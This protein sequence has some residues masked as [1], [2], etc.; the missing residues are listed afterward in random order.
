MSDTILIHN[1]RVYLPDEL[2]DPGW[3]LIAGKRITQI[4]QG[5]PPVGLQST[6]SIDAG[7]KHLLPGFIDLHIHGSAGYEVMDCDPEGILGMA[8][9]LVT[10]G[11]TGFLATTL[12]APHE[13]IMAAIQA[14]KRANEQP[15]EGWAAILGVHLEGP[16]LNPERCGAQDPGQIRRADLREF[17]ELN[18]SGQVRLVTL[19]PE[20]PENLW[21][22]AACKERGITVSA[23]HTSANQE[24]MKV[25][26]ELGLNHVT[27]IYNAM[28]PLNH[29]EMGT[30]GAALALDELN[31]EIICDNVHVHPMAQKIVV[32]CKGTDRVILISDA[33]C[34]AGLPEGEYMMNQQKVFTRDGAAYLQNG[35]LAGSIISIDKALKNILE[36]CDLSLEQGWCMS[37]LNAAKAIHM[38]NI[39]GSIAPGKDADLVLLDEEL[40]VCMTMVEGKIVYEV[41][42]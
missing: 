9:F 2:L 15:L 39:N 21:L 13:R 11:V 12:T 3:V 22:I 38:D 14:V 26:I 30:V 7:G 6:G 24:Q 42:T 10:H 16:Y 41:S 37:S 32:R 33:L 40:G 18:E 23:G 36:N 28:A 31:C 29:R 20:F 19:A 35:S 1:A 25:A 17:S 34:C 27:H 8:R 5:G 4:G